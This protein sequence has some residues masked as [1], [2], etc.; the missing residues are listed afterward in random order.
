MYGPWNMS[1]LGGMGFDAFYCHFKWE[2]ELAHPGLTEQRMGK[3]SIEAAAHNVT[4]IA[5]QYYMQPVWSLITFNY[6]RAVTMGGA[7]DALSPSP[8]DEAWWLHLVEEPALFLANLSLYYPIWGV[9][10]DFE[11][12]GHDTYTGHDR[13]TY[14]SAALAAFGQSAGVAVP[15]LPSGQRYPWLV[16][17]GL[18]DRYHE[19]LREKAFTMARSTERKVHAINPNLSLGILGFFNAWFHW[20]VLEG[21][22]SSTAPVT[23]WC[24]QT[25]GGYKLGGTEGVDVYRRMWAEHRLYGKFLPGL[26]SSIKS[27]EAAIRDNGAFWSYEY[28]GHWWQQYGEV[29]KK[30]YERMHRAFDSLFFFNTDDVHPLPIL[31]LLPGVEARPYLSANG[32][33]TVLLQ[34]YSV[35]LPMNM[36]IL[37]DATEILYMWFDVDWLQQDDCHIRIIP[38]SDAVLGIDELPCVISWLRAEDLVRTEA[39]ALIREL[40]QLLTLYD[41]A[42]LS[43]PPW[44]S[45][46]LESAAAEFKAA[47]Y[48]SARDRVLQTRNQTYAFGI[49]AIWPLVQSGLANPRESRIPL[50]ILRTLSTA[51]RMFDDAKP[52]L[53]EIYFMEGLQDIV[54]QVAETGILWALT[55]VGALIIGCRATSAR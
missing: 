10:W 38:S 49:E 35:I 50:P 51:K 30:R 25:Y 48:A 39:W 33:C 9:V 20:S 32:T 53:G 12:Y 34:P 21:W 14:D 6:T 31:D 13:Y 7:V 3:E 43:R 41:R 27:M 28:D 17:N 2:S 18:L 52:R 11:L 22:N 47:D 23:A 8:V 15:S 44:G 29:L 19:W 46:V 36:T 42:G 40:D 54:A 5:G 24:E 45:T 16:S 37:T 55:V 26:R 4:Y 1:E